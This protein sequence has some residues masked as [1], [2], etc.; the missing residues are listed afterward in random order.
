M[1][2][3]TR[4]Q[5]GEGERLREALLDAAAEILASSHD[6]DVLSVRAVT[7]RAG[8]SPTAMY[9]HFEDKEALA[10]EVKR[11]CFAAFGAAL[12]AAAAEHPDDPRAGVR[13]RGVAY[14]RFAREHP[15]QYAILFHTY[16]P[17]KGAVPA[18]PEEVGLGMDTFEAHVAGVARA[19]PGDPRAFDLSTIL[20]MALHGRAAVRSAMPKFPFPDEETYVSL[21]VE[22][23]LGPPA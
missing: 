14:L 4:N 8:V 18:D 12:D 11:R 20:W 17:K 21:L 13:A 3:R 23:V 5:R 7:A 1:A 22:Q 19:L 6:A 2:T 15:G 9:L 10:A 16:V